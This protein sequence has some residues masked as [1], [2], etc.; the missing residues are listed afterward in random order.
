VAGKARGSCLCGGVAY[1]IGGPVAGPIA[2]CHC[3]RCR[4][5]RA[6]AHASNLF[7]E[8]SNFRWLRGEELV[9]SYKVPEAERFTQAFCRTCGAKVPH[10]NAARGRVVVPA[11]SL[12][13]DPGALLGVEEPLVGAE[14][15]ME[16][17]GVVE[18]R[19][20]VVGIVPRDRVR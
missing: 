5:A 20:D 15:P 19:H 10:L 6:A 3:S 7:A 2:N 9:V 13:D 17:H 12:D 1:E 16:P 4:K 18:A 8:L 11:G 14:G